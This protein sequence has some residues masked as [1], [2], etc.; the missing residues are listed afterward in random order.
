VARRRRRAHAA[1]AYLGLS[2]AGLAG[3]RAI[4]IAGIKTSDVAAFD[5]Y[6]C[7]PIAVFDLR[8]ELGIPANDPPPRTVTGGL[9]FFGGAGNNYS[10]H[11]IAS[12][13]RFLRGNPGSYGFVGANGGFLSKYS[14][15]VYS[16]KPRPWQFSSRICRRRSTPGPRKAAADNENSGAVGNTIDYS[17]EQ[18]AAFSSCAAIGTR[19]AAMTD[20]TTA[21]SSAHGQEEPLGAAIETRPRRQ[22]PPCGDAL[23]AE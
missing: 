6:S 19:F 16:T 11:A 22:R 18:P 2:P 5:L 7:F 23:H 13:V 20:R 17:R 9:P 12:M 10:M 14:V 3:R 4:E 1:R 21:P 15:G 8:D